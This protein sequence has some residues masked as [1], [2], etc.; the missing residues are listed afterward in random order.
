[1]YQRTQ[2]LPFGKSSAAVNAI[3]VCP[4]KKCALKT[5][6]WVYLV[7]PL[8]F[9]SDFNVTLK[10]KWKLPRNSVLLLVTCRIIAYSD[11]GVYL[12][13]CY[14]VFMF[15]VIYGTSLLL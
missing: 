3:Y 1:M 12:I 7:V 13:K 14:A 8:K 11:D 10:R 2:H 9:Q 5:P 4:E 15:A 6:C